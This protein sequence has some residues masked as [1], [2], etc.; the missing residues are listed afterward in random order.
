MINNNHSKLN[1]I[2]GHKS[3]N[4]NGIYW[5]FYDVHTASLKACAVKT[6]LYDDIS[7]SYCHPEDCQKQPFIYK[8]E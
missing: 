2:E 3:T 4:I 6:A 8:K 5:I 1:E 7:L